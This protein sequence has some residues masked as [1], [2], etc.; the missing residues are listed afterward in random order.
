MKV[1]YWAVLLNEKSKQKLL[2]KHKPRHQKVYA[3]HMTILFGPTSEQNDKLIE[4]AGEVVTLTVVGS[5]S[6]DKGDAVVVTGESRLNG[7][8]SHITISCGDKIRPSYSNELLGDGWNSTEP[9]TLYGTIARY[10][11]NGWNKSS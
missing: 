11:K 9:L 8:V 1:I 5:K 6:D 2:E 7:G 3:E 10:T 4:R